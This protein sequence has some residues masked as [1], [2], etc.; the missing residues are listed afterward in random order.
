MCLMENSAG[1]TRK[2][3]QRK[4]PIKAFKC[5]RVNFD[6]KDSLSSILYNA[7]KPLK[8]S[9]SGVVVSNRRKSHL[10][11]KEIRHNI[12]E[13]GIHVSNFKEAK[14]YLLDRC[15]L[16]PVT[17][18]PSDLVGTKINRSCMVFKKITLDMKAVATEIAALKKRQGMYA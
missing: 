6:D 7:D 3:R 5:Y 11:P 15:I 14:S 18:R 16:V 13:K 4:T 9:R 12:V 1:Q 17:G 10:T 8:I 2:L